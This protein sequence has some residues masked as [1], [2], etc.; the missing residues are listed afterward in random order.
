[1]FKWNAFCSV[2]WLAVS[3]TLLW[4]ETRNKS[5]TTIVTW[6][7]KS[8]SLAMVEGYFLLTCLAPLGRRWEAGERRE[9]GDPVLT[10]LSGSV[11]LFSQYWGMPFCLTTYASPVPVKILLHL[12]FLCIV[13]Y[14]ALCYIVCVYLCAQVCVFFSCPPHYCQL[15]RA[16]RAMLSS[17]DNS[18]NF[19]FRKS[20][21]VV[22]TE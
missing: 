5:T 2:F 3:S 14:K 4:Y 12:H 18:R 1:M 8:V 7:N 11:A 21:N 10:N 20:I 17:I 13:F 16:G 9:A 15:C 22:V 6:V 19:V